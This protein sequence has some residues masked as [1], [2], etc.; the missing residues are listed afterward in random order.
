M[1]ASALQIPD[2]IVSLNAEVLE[3]IQ[4]FGISAREAD[5]LRLLLSG[6]T[7]AAPMAKILK[8]SPHTVNN[9]LRRIYE[10]TGTSNKT[11]IVAAFVRFVLSKLNHCKLFTK[12]PKVLV[13]DDEPE[14]GKLV[15][16]FLV[17]KGVKVHIETDP[18]L[19]LAK[20]RELE[21]DFVVSDIDMPA[22]NGLNLLREIRAIHR[23]LPAVILITGK[24]MDYSVEQSMDLGAVNFIAKPLNLNQLFFTI[25]ER[26]IEGPHERSR[27]LR[28][29]TRIS[30]TIEG[31]FPLTIT[32][33][34][35]GG[36]FLPFERGLLGAERRFKV[37]D[38]VAFDFSLGEG[39]PA[40]HAEGE[41]V[42]RRD[43][44]ALDVAPGVGVKFTKLDDAD[45]AAVEE[46]VRVNKI[47]SFIPIGA[48]SAPGR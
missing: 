10:R 19:A 45:R 9:H 32:N 25:M 41:V 30:A 8:I 2:N 37:G 14:I 34:G 38:Q 43:A 22:L 48:V 4:S 1:K 24:T 36:A 16:E 13:L 12:Q 47:A 3:F 11:E 5:V 40:I 27:L 15:A 35:F 33:L 31:V 7:A 18:V 23:R 39:A 28:V 44:A 26:F 21:L 20:V 6:V 42:W 29:D 46:F 17:A